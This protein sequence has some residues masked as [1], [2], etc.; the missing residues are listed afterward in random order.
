[1]MAQVKIIKFFKF[2]NFFL[3]FCSKKIK[4]MQAQGWK[5]IE[6]ST[7]KPA[8]TPPYNNIQQYQLNRY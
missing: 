6:N 8:I 7:T 3:K 5:F 2:L 1:M 4:K